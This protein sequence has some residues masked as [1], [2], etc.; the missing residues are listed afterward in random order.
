MKLKSK[1]FNILNKTEEIESYLPE[2]FE[3][4]SISFK[5]LN[6]LWVSCRR[7]PLKYWLSTKETNIL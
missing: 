4:K 6:P 5:T 7:I 2:Y 1:I 3:R